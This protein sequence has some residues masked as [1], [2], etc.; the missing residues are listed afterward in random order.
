MINSIKNIKYSYPVSFK[1]QRYQNP[2]DKYK[3]SDSER[4]YISQFSCAYDYIDSTQQTWENYQKL[5]EN[6][7][8]SWLINV[9][10]DESKCPW[11]IHIYA[12]NEKDYTLLYAIL[13]KYILD[14]D[15]EAKIIFPHE[16]ETLNSNNQ[17]GKSLAIFSKSSFDLG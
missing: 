13:T 14:N 7:M 10:R 2:L 15:I 8:G 16:L 12:D 5:F 6:S 11:K 3:L 1:G 17:K 4:R 9:A